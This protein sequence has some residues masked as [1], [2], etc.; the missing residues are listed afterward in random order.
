[1]MMVLIVNRESW[2][3]SNPSS[4][5]MQHGRGPRRVQPSSFT[6]RVVTIRRRAW[7]C[8]GHQQE[9]RICCDN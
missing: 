3:R 6:S 4:S 2:R 1:M 8:L 5:H 9:S 7:L